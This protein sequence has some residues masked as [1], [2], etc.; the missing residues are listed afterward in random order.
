MFFCVVIKIYRIKSLRA[1]KTLIRSYLRNKASSTLIS[2]DKLC[3][4]VPGISTVSNAINLSIKLFTS[5]IDCSGRDYLNHL[6]RK[7][8]LQC[9]FAAIPMAKVVAKLGKCNIFSSAPHVI[10]SGAL[11]ADLIF[12][13]ETTV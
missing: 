11:K 2:L 13:R 12:F 10:T 7:S 1:R 4:Y 5:C 8:T 9:L 6:Q 3:D